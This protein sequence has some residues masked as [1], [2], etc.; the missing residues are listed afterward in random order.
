MRTMLL[1]IFLFYYAGIIA[2]QGPC[3][4]ETILNMKG[5]WKKRS[6]QN[7]RGDQNITEIHKRLEN[8]SE[9]FKNAYPEP[10][11]IEANWYASMNSNPVMSN[12]P[13]PYNFNSLYL[14]WYCNQ[15]LKKMMLGD[16]TGTWAYVFVN[17]F[18][19]FLSDQYDLLRI[20]SNENPVYLLPEKKGEWKSYALYQTNSGGEK[21]RCLILTRNDLLPWKPISQENY[22]EAIRV[23]WEEQK[24]KLADNYSIQEDNIKKSM[25]DNKNNKYL[26]DTDK[27]KINASLQKRLD[28]LQK[29][30]DQNTA[31]TNKYWDDKINTLD[32]YLKHTDAATLQSAAIID[33]QTAG[34][35]KGTFTTEQKGGRML[36]VTNPEYF[37]M[38]LP[39]YAPQFMILFWRWDNKAPAMDFKKQFEDGFPVEKLKAMLDK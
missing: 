7:M 27:E 18:S 33:K 21:S 23:Q 26:K 28:D 12:G 6:D 14:S 8:I 38:K 32:N 39:R 10:K 30:K 3:N 29:T 17:N 11:G 5:S 9:L 35:F 24:K 16:E 13:V 36:V 31:K 1:F 37:N 25:A 15:N 22:L 2:A 20:K 34:D 19:W 4:D